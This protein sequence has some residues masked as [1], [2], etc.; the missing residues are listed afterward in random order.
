MNVMENNQ[1]F[2]EI[3]NTF[4]FVVEKENIRDKTGITTTHSSAANLLLK[5]I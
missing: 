4:D 1:V 2:V 3:C 5:I